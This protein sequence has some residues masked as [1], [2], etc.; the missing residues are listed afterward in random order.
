[1]V[2]ASEPVGGR[3]QATELPCFT[4]M[5]LNI[6]DAGSHLS[7]AGSSL[8]G[9]KPANGVPKANGVTEKATNGETGT[10][11]DL[12][13]NNNNSK[14]HIFPAAKDKSLRCDMNESNLK[15]NFVQSD[16]LDVPS[17]P[18]FTTPMADTQAGG[19]LC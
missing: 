19:I 17:S 8:S 6:F 16:A 10:E 1:M 9:E 3:S 12:N 7:D 4:H 2:L 5:L 18:C 14:L 11:D 13:A 15:S